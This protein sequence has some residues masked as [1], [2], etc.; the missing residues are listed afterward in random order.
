[1]TAYL[2]RFID[3]DLRASLV[4]KELKGKSGLTLYN[5]FNRV[6]LFLVEVMKA[7]YVIKNKVI[8]NKAVHVVLRIV[9]GRSKQSQA[10]EQNKRIRNF[11]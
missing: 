4:L 9:W 1:M 7:G 5:D 3:V 2:K 10:E 11:I 8:T 6:Y